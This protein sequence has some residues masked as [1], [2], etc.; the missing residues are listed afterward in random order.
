MTAIK[1]DRRRRPGSPNKGLPAFGLAPTDATAYAFPHAPSATLAAPAYV[2]ANPTVASPFAAAYSESSD[3][4]HAEH[5]GLE[6]S[7]SDMSSG[8]W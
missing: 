1:N 5:V 2:S 4:A 3:L 8:S 6:V 7:G